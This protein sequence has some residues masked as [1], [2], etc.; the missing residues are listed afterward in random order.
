[1]PVP[2][3]A[4]QVREVAKMGTVES[5]WTFH[6]VFGDRGDDIEFSDIAEGKCIVPVVTA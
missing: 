2:F 5:D 3:S 1:V 4:D 6:Q